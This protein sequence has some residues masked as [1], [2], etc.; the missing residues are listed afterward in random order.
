MP[1]Y[2]TTLLKFTIILKHIKEK[3]KVSWGSTICAI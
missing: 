1:D 3:Y 2:G